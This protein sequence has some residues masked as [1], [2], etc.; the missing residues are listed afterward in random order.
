MSRVRLQGWPRDFTT[1]YDKRE[2]QALMPQILAAME[3]V[4]EMCRPAEDDYILTKIEILES[5]YF[6]SDLDDSTQKALDEEWLED[7]EEYPADLIARACKNWRRGN[8]NFAPRSAGV[9]MESVKSE[10]VRRQTI[11]RNGE[12]IMRLLGVAQ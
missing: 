1:E 7:L 10:W 12:N 8:N 11:M 2:A 4:S 6:V 3:Y 9:L 5:R